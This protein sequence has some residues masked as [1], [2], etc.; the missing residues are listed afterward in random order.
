MAKS[1]ISNER[2]C[3][4]CEQPY[5]LHKH[6][7]FFGTGLRKLSEKYGCWV[8]LCSYHHNG[9]NDAVHFNKR[10]DKVLKE[11]TQK[12]FEEVYPDLDFVQIFGRNYKE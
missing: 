2:V 12:K 6:H 3:V 11:N 8:Y 1:I 5:N 4:I 7:V 10:F 9:S